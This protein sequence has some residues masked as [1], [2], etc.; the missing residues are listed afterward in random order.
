MTTVKWQLR[1][2]MAERGMFQTT[3]LGRLLA[4]HGVI[5]SREQVYRLVTSTPQRLNMEVLVALCTI[6]DCTPND[7]IRVEAA[8]ATGDSKVAAGA[9]SSTTTVP[10]GLAPVR[11]QIVRPS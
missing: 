9:G 6:L 10:A 5:V 8:A 7:L 4:E 11:A 3:D 2:L 1:K